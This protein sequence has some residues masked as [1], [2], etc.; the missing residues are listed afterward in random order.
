MGDDFGF[1]HSESLRE[2]CIKPAQCDWPRVTGITAS[3]VVMKRSNFER[4][5][6]R[7][8]MVE[9]KTVVVTF[10]SRAHIRSSTY[11]LPS[12]EFVPNAIVHLTIS[13]SQ[14]ETCECIPLRHFCLL[15]QGSGINAPLVY[16][17]LKSYS[18]SRRLI[19][20]LYAYD[21]RLICQSFFVIVPSSKRA[22]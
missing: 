2:S 13:S 1:R 11:C 19:P 5:M 4:H 16:C 18:S 3:T 17:S 14:Y 9:S 20:G 22:V 15:P 8:T 7:S 6:H 10:G 21:E 12:S